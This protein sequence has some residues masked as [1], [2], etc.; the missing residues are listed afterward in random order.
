M[1]K[2]ILSFI[3]VMSFLF[4][5]AQTK[6]NGSSAK[7]LE[8]NMSDSTK[9]D[10]NPNLQSFDKQPLPASEYG[11]KKDILYKKR[12]ALRNLKGAIKKKSTEG[13]EVIPSIIKQF[14]A[15]ATNSN[16][17]NND[18]AVGNDGTII[19]VVNSNIAI[20]NSAGTLVQTK[21][22]A[23]F[24]SQLGSIGLTS[25]PR[26]LYDANK[27]RFVFLFFTGILSTTNQIIV[28]FSKTN[29]PAGLWN[30]YKLPGNSFKDSTWSDYPI[31]SLSKSDLFFTFNQVKDNI[32][33][34]IGFKQ[35]VIWQLD[36]DR[37]YNGDSL[38]Y[39]LWS[40]LKLNG[41][42]Y[43]N[44]CPAK[45][46]SINPGDNMYFLTV[47]NVDF[48]ND[49]IFLHEITNSYASGNA[50]F[51]SKVI[52]SPVKYGFPPN[53]F[54]AK[55][56]TGKIQQ[57]STND[58]RVL[59]AI[60]EN[61]YIHFGSNSINPQYTNAGIMLGT[62]K[63]VSKTMPTVTTKIFSSPTIE[64]GY[65]SMA[66]IEDT[67]IKHRVVYTFS[68]CVTDSMPGMSMVYQNT[69]GEFSA[70]QRIKNGLSIIDL[71]TAQ[72]ER[73]GDYSNAQRNHANINQAYLVGSFGNLNRM[74]TWI[75][76]LEVNDTVLPPPPPPPS[77]IS[78]SETNTNIDLFPNPSQNKFT[79][80]FEITENEYLKFSITSIDGKLIADILYE[81]AFKGKNEFSIN[82]NS[83][84]KGLYYLKIKGDKLTDISRK[85]EKE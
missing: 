76:K 19:S 56:G 59:A 52:K 31:L 7:P 48:S 54:Q 17:A 41:T 45:P 78:S 65:P 75:A 39:T 77:S 9:P 74:K 66:Q 33:W 26:V 53:A 72:I 80:S 81:K 30:F 43:R 38:K 84:P 20:Y 79:T 82:T 15:N 46:Q 1:Q 14:E 44:I 18:I 62:I 22:L 27:D 4:G 57:L 71:D 3:L 63:N 83:L 13:N 5:I 49:S 64:Y 85:F 36:K 37:G 60:Y 61:D 69:N 50:Q 42:N 10:Y 32:D 11:D 24:A 23:S 40:D 28:G 25:D 8:I 29:N 58:A 47:R 73:W 12:M 16:P 2:N 34:R 67:I 55:N 51:K 70:I 35:S 6:T 68:H 21:S